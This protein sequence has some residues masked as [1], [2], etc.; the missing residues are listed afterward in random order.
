MPGGESDVNVILA[1]LEHV[2]GD[3]KALCVEMREMRKDLSSLKLQVKDT[4]IPKRTCVEIQK[5]CNSKMDT[6]VT[7]EEFDPIKKVVFFMIFILLAAVGKATLQ[8]LK[9]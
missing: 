2:Q 5:R 1:H 7:K 8:G 9:F 6:A 3:I 4:Y